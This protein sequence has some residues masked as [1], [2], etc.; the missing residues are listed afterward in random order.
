MQQAVSAA[1][2]LQEAGSAAAEDAAWLNAVPEAGRPRSAAHKVGPGDCST[3][4]LC[5]A[6]W[7]LLIG[8]VFNITRLML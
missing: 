5:P 2:G 7:D 1:V 8:I 6:L 4:C 3:L